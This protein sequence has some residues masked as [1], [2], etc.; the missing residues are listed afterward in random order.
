M[1]EKE[2]KMSLVID[3]LRG[4]TTSQQTDAKQLAL[5]RDGANNELARAR[6][7]IARLQQANAALQ[8]RY[9]ER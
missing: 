3:E 6:A 9:K 5:A 7:E 2:R 1:Q 8:A 4:Q